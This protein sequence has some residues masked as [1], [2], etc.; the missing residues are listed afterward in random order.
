[1]AE[2]HHSM[3]VLPDGRVVLEAGDQKLTLFPQE[4]AFLRRLMN[5]ASKPPKASCLSALV[6]Q[7]E[8][9]ARRSGC[10]FSEPG[11]SFAPISALNSEGRCTRCISTLAGG[12]LCP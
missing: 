9:T 6:E 11:D 12:S 8:A 1:M 2:R 5:R 4:I 7:Q 10:L 3:T